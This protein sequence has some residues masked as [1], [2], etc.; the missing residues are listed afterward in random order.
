MTLASSS[1]VMADTERSMVESQKRQRT[2]DWPSGK[3]SGAPQLGQLRERGAAS[4]MVVLEKLEAVGWM[5]GSIIEPVA[6]A[7]EW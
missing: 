4:V 6:W 5:A 7:A 3:S 1:S 2:L